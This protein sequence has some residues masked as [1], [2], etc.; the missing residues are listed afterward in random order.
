MRHRRKKRV[1]VK[2][3]VSAISQKSRSHAEGVKG[4]PAQAQRSELRGERRNSGMS[5]LSALAGSEGY[6]ACDD[7]GDWGPPQQAQTADFR[8]SG[9][10]TV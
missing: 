1:S 8:M 10:R 4:V 2:L 9:N 6:G 3:P 7:E 5:E